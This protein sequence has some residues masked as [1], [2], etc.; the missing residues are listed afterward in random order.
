MTDNKAIMSLFDPGRNV[1]PQ[2]YGRIQRWSLKL[3]MYRYTLQFCPTAQHANADAL[4]RLPLPEKP[5]SVPLPGELVLLIDYLA[6]AP[7]TAAQLKTWTAKDKLLSKVLHFIRYGWPNEMVDSE[8]KPYFIKRWKLI[9]LD[10]CIIWCSRVLI[11]PPAREHILAELHGGHPGGAKMKSLVCKFLWWPGMDCQI[12][13]TVKAYPECQQSQLAPSV[14]PLCS[15]QWPTRPWSCLHIDFTGPMDNLTYLV[16]IDAHSKWIEVFKMNSTTAIAT[17]EVL[18][19]VFARIGIPE[20]IVSDNGPQFTS[21]EFTK[22]YELNGIRHVRVPPYHPSSNGLTERAV[23]TFKK[24]FKKSSKGSVQDKISHFLFSYRIMPQSTT[25]TSPAELLFGRPLRSRLHLLKPNLS[26]NVENKQEQQKLSHD[27]CAVERIFVEGEKVFVR[28]YSKVGKK[29]LPGK[30]FSVAQ[31]SVK[32]K[33]TSG[34]VIHRHFDQI[35]KRTVDEPTVEPA[36]ECDSKAYTYISVNSDE[37]V[38][39]ETVTSPEAS[40][41]EPTPHTRRYP[42]RIRKAPDRLNL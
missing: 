5:T 10:G 41:A 33:L 13:E 32:V 9:E 8:M 29:W 24:G 39:S 3:T 25:G 14:A 28:N 16:I 26:Q 21:S 35:R 22:F 27:K 30:V 42:L 23:Q 20:S 2:V 4:S 17:I 36:S 1:S 7:I 11:P 18:R 6:E 38:V 31:R 40:A 12:E 37:S 15:W 19:T 34:L